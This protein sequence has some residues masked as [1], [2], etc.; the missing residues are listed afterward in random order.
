MVGATGSNQTAKAR[1]TATAF[2]FNASNNVLNAAAF[3]ASGTDQNIT[4]NESG[5]TSAW[6]ARILSKNSAADRAVFLGTYGTNT[7][8]FAHNHALNGWATLFVNTADGSSDG[9]NVIIAGSG[10]LG[11]GNA[12]PSTKLDVTGTITASGQ[13]I[14]TRA[15]STTTGGGQ[16]YLN[17]ATGNRIDFNTNGVAAPAF[18][19]RSAGT[20]IVLYPVLNASQADYAFGIDTSTL[21]SSVPTTSEQFKWYAGTT[22]IATLSGASVLT[23]A[24]DGSTLY[25][26]NTTWGAYLRVGG[27]GNADTTNASVVATNGNLHI[28]A[29]SGAYNIY[30][31]YY[32]GTG[33]TAFGNGAS[34]TVAWMGPDGDLWK[35][36][37]DNTGDKYWHAG[38]DGAGSGLDADLLDGENLVDNA[39]TANTVV[40]RDATGGVTATTFTSTSDISQKNNIRNITNA[41]ELINQINGVRFNW[42]SNNEPSAGVIAQEVEKVLP[43]VVRVDSTGIKAVNYNGLVGLLIEAIKEQQVHINNLHNEVN[44]LKERRSN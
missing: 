34:G 21:W 39:S 27:N 33:G 36:S 26:P 42:V 22:N 43:E 17:G 18:T 25:G 29:R 1:S 6:R 37:A 7:G 9:G 44:Q 10:N 4:A 40:G 28:D 19:T 35:G 38:N 13:L 11:V 30:L 2:S 32:K 31:N 23:I 5:T 41:V 14:S 15:N 16:I 3:S 12:S 8:V 24:T 20:K